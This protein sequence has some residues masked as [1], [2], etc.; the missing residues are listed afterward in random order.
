MGL[1]AWGAGS[2]DTSYVLSLTPSKQNGQ[3]V[4]NKLMSQCVIAPWVNSKETNPR[5]G[6][7]STIIVA[8]S[9]RPATTITPT[10]FVTA[11]AA[12]S[13]KSDE[14]VLTVHIL[15]DTSL[16]QTASVPSSLTVLITAP[17]APNDNSY[18]IALATPTDTPAPV[19][20][21]PATTTSPSPTPTGGA[22][23]IQITALIWGCMLLPFLL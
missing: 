10:T 8:P 4:D 13:S 20:T 12:K 7:T 3:L 16:V 21:K 19:Q 2:F 11:S 9:T 23:L 6:E 22:S 5:D 1:V 14:P 18:S 17:G 15:S